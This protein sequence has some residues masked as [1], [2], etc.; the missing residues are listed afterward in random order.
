MTHSDVVSPRGFLQT[1]RIEILIFVVALLARL[2]YLYVSIAH[3]GGDLIGAISGADGYFQVARNIIAGHGFTSSLTPPYVPYS[4]RPPLYQY[5]IA[6]IYELFRSYWGVIIVQVLLGSLLPLI[7]MSLVKRV[8]RSRTAILSIGFLLAL[9][10]T[11]ILHATFF[12]AEIVFTFLFL[13]SLLWLFRYIERKQLHL[14]LLSAAAL[15]L[16]CLTRPAVEYLPIGIIGCLV[17]DARKRLTR[18]FFAHMGAYLLVFIAVIAPWSY[19]NYALFGVADLTPQLGVNLY[20]VL[21][22]S[23]LSVENGTSWQ[24]EYDALTQGGAVKGPNE[25]DITQGGEYTHRAIP[26]LLEHQKG[27]V[28]I[29]ATSALSFFTSDGVLDFL[30]HIGAATP[31]RFGKPV[32]FVLF[33]SPSALLSAIAQVAMTPT[34]FVLFMRVFWIIATLLFFFGAWRYVRREGGAAALIMATVV[35]YSALTTLIGGLG[36]TARYRFP[37]NALILAF[38]AYALISLVGTVKQK[39]RQGYA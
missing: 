18:K 11:G 22:P 29:M 24:Q 37:V 14:L 25:A 27:L 15:G 7:S 34:I 31:L 9:D 8:V 10:P 1:Y 30:R 23:V 4:F 3:A 13:V 5:F 33:S 2:A 19:R 38:A 35:L 26:I 20:T 36:V 32:L 16:A 6:G 39:L 28:I 21:V 12:Y 17:W